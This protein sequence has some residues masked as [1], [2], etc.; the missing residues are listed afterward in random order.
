MRQRVADGISGPPLAV[1]TVGPKSAWEHQL[2]LA[3]VPQTG[4]PRHRGQLCA[5]TAPI[6]PSGL[7]AAV[8]GPKQDAAAELQ[9]NRE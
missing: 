3:V 8:N 1:G 9:R 4:S 5:F 6:G 2:E 7:S